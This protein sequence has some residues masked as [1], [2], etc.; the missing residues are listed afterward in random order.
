M[1][2]M[3]RLLLDHIAL[4]YYPYSELTAAPT[5]KIPSASVNLCLNIDT[6]S[7]TFSV[8]HA[9]L[10]VEGV[11]VSHPEVYNDGRYIVHG[12]RT[13]LQPLS[14]YSCFDRSHSYHCHGDSMP[15]R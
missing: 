2:S 11:E 10:F 15:T 1:C 8:H 12:L 13:F 9:R 7:G 6:V 5:I 14:R 4:G 3:R